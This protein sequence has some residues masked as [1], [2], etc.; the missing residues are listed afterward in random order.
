[1]STKSPRKEFWQGFKDTIPLNVSGIPFG[2]IFGALAIATGISPMTTLG[3]SL[4]VAAGASQMMAVGLVGQHTPIPIIWLTT[5]I[6]NARHALY[7]TTLAPYTKHLSHRWQL[8]LGYLLNDEAF[9]VAI[10]RYNEADP[11]PHKHWYF[12]GSAVS[13]YGFWQ[14]S[15]LIGILAGSTIDDP[16][17]WGL[18]FTMTVTFTAM[19]V[20]QIKTRPI[21]VCVVVSAITAVLA[22]GIAYQL[23]LL[24]ASICGVTA[25]ILAEKRWGQATPQVEKG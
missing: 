18:D 24:V 11:S 1:M 15:T 9:V 23:G 25:G 6:V 21:L 16:L 10:Q 14:V 2:I 17:A 7:A 3:L 8:I 20:S 22:N 4:F 5:F 19:L 12:L 13:L